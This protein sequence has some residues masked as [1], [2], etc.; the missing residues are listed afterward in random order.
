[1]DCAFHATIAVH[2]FLTGALHLLQ[3]IFAAATMKLFYKTISYLF[4][5]GTFALGGFLYLN[6]L[7]GSIQWEFL[8]WTAFFFALLPVVGIY[9]LV[10][11][12]FISDIHIYKREQRNL[13]YPIAIAGAAI[14]CAYVY[15]VQTDERLFAWS[16]A[17]TLSL[18]LL[19][20]LNATWIKVSAHMT[21]VS[22]FTALQLYLFSQGEENIA[23]LSISLLLCLLVYL[24]RKGLSAHSHKELIAGFC[25]GF[26]A[27]FA[28]LSL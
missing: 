28:T 12:G 8:F 4:F 14:G 11:M 26:L 25:L 9:S 15:Y 20:I 16:L 13:S 10:R 21:G 2:S 3:A 17:A 18:F 27:T 22:G 24:S 7:D 5:P 19:W 6:V 1:M 23:M